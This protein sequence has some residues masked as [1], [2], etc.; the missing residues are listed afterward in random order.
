MSDDQITGFRTTFHAMTGAQHAGAPR[1]GYIEIPLFQRDYAQGRDDQRTRAIRSRFLDALHAALTGETSLGLD[2]IYGEVRDGKLEPLDGQQRLTTL[3]LLH[4]YVASRCDALDDGQGWKGFTYATRPSAR[5]FCERLTKHPLPLTA[6]SDVSAWITDQSWYLHLWRFDP[7]VQAMLVTLNAI[8]ERFAADDAERLWARLTDESDPA[9]WFQLLPIHEMGA[10]DALY[11]KMNSRG[12]PLTAFEAFKAG[13]SAKRATTGFDEAGEAAFFGAL[14]SAFDRGWAAR[15]APGHDDPA[16]VFIL[17]QPRTGTTLA[18][19][20][21]ASHSMAEAAGELQ[22]FGLCV[23][24]LAGSSDPAAWARLDPRALGEAYIKAA[25]PMRTG[26]PRFIDKL[27][28][29]FLYLP[30][31]ARALPRARIVHLTR[32]PLDACFASYKQLFAEAYPHSYDQQEMARHFVRYSDL[33][34]HWRAILPGAFLDVAY[35]RLA[36]DTEAEA[37]RL[38]AFLDLPWEDACLRFHELDAPVATASAAQVREAAHT[39]SV[40]RAA[41]YGDR[42]APMRLILAAAGLQPSVVDA[43]KR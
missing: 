15:E 11:I 2:F 41:R 3:F 34:A 29:N 20:I 12:K 39:R 43:E 32:D 8:A 23:R 25:A 1:V 26:K 22:Q 6:G 5:L 21:I 9:I 40:G 7:T 19:R 31:I 18:E 35:E 30:L 24:R 27:P 37:R 36:S 38:L 4:W 33:M 28:R 42:L 14:Q 13:A 16:P 17:G 10:A